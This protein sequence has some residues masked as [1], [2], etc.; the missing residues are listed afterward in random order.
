MY[1]IKRVLI[2]V[3]L[4]AVLT[5]ITTSVYAIPPQQEV[6]H[7]GWM[8]FLTVD[9]QIN[10]TVFEGGYLWCVTSRGIIIWDTTD[11]TYVKYNTKQDLSYRS[12]V[13]DSN[14]VK[15]FGTVDGGVNRFD[16]E[17]W[18][19]YTTTDGLADNFVYT[20]AIDGDGAK[21]FGTENGVSRFDGETWT[22]YTTVDGLADNRVNT[23]AI[24]I[25]GA[26]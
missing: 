19:T 18:T 22:T 10:G 23:I 7:E 5:S 24:D 2:A 16:G 6:I 21:W 26:K 15:W 4:V 9:N 20:I 14:G 17:T 8:N 13:L 11:N 1:N 25:D 3:F 12:I